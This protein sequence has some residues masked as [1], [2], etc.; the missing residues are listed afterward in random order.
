MVFKKNFGHTL[1]EML[2]TVGVFFM[3]AL[4]IPWGIR[5]INILSKKGH[6]VELERDAQVALYLMT[7]EVRN[8]RLIMSISPTTLVLSAYNLTG[9]YDSDV[10]AAIFDRNLWG[11]ITYQF[12]QLGQ[13][14]YLNKK[15]EFPDPVTLLMRTTLEKKL[16]RNMLVAPN[17]TNYIFENNSLSPTCPC[18]SVK[19]ALRLNPGY[20]RDAPLV[21]ET[22]A[23]IRSLGGG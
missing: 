13:E 17:P 12:Q 20:F 8:S 14:T 15:V 2:I 22:S 7:K 4:M 6:A 18:D 21:Y 5:F 10:N 16:F 23:E 19:I 11:T 1:T 9:G 3:I